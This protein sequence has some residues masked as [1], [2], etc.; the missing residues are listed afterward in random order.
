VQAAPAPQASAAEIE[1]LLREAGLTMAVTDPKKLHAVQA[2]SENVAPAVRAPR[3]RKQMPTVP[4]E[5]L[6]QVETRS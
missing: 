2:V 5:P 4:D 1:R 3:E 6:M